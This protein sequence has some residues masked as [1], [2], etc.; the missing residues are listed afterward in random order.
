MAL[1]NSELLYSLEEYL[2]LERRSEERHEYL[3]GFIWLMAGESGAHADICT[4]LTRIV[5]T[6]LLGTRCRARSKDT[7]VRSGPAPRSRRATKGLFSYPDLVVICDEPQY[8]DK[9]RDVVTNSAVIIEVLSESTEAFDRGEKFLRYQVWN[10][11][12]TD[13]LLVSQDKPLVEHF[14]RHS[15]GSW[16]YRFYQ[17]LEQGAQINSIDCVLNPSEVYDRVV[18]PPVE[19]EIADEGESSH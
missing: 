18:F 11:T 7:K 4:N 14:A 3:D 10:P 12:L 1:P 8:Q 19:D 17:G 9:H 5:S 6:Q 13:Y 15:D 16:V 2:D